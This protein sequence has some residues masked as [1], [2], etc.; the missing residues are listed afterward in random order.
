MTKEQLQQAKVLDD[1]M[2]KL[3]GGLHQI[4]EV[5]FRDSDP[6]NGTNL[7]KLRTFMDQFGDNKLLVEMLNLLEAKMKAE[8]KEHETK[9]ALL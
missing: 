1:R 6:I 8:L 5:S 4:K 9:F 7:D 2:H 3:K